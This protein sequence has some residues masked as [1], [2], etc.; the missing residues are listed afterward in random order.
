MGYEHSESPKIRVGKEWEIGKRKLE[1]DTGVEEEE[2]KG[3]QKMGESENE[4]SKQVME[5]RR[6]EGE[7]WKETW[8]RRR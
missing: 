6:E 1:K 5:R 4:K 2:K 8:K 7:A 3:D